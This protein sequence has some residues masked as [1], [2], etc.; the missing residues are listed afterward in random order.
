MAE[1]FT[2]D[3][4]AANR[5]RIVV[6]DLEPACV[7]RILEVLDTIRRDGVAN[8]FDRQR[9]GSLGQSGEFIA[10]PWCLG[11]YERT[12]WLAIADPN[13]HDRP[14]DR[15]EKEILRRHWGDWPAC[16]RQVRDPARRRVIDLLAHQPGDFRRAIARIDI[17]LRGLYLAAYQSYLWNRMLGDLVRETC[18]PGVLR[19]VSLAAHTVPLFLHLAD[20]E[21]ERL[22]EVVLPLPSAREKPASEPVAALLGRVLAREGLD[23]HQLRVKY[24]RDSFFS[25]GERSAIV[26]PA[27]LTGTIRDDDLYPHRS[28]LDLAFA[29]PRAAYASMVTLTLEVALRE[30][31]P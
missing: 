16:Q 29:L 14:A 19:D 24:P 17:D 28:R 13:D 27:E 30:A 9:F 8:Y 26:M 4:I 10:R 20:T 18:S 21:R 3:H 25:K 1:A 12:V 22:A 6:R 5:F 7:P 11:N 31:A 23:R 15:A 2:S